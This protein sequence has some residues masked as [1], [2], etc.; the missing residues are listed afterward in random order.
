V[1]PFGVAF[2]HQHL[3]LIPP[4]TVLENLM[5]TRLAGRGGIARPWAINWGRERSAAR[6]LFKRY[7]LVSRITEARY[8]ALCLKS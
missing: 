2:V 5:L 1:R 8:V 4:V 6:R 7:G 3:G